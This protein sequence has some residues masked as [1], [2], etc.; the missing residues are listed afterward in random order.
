MTDKPVLFGWCGDN[1]HAQCKK[2]FQYENKQIVC[3][4]DCHKK[5]ATNE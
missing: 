2:E 1:H 4:C 3:E 5:E